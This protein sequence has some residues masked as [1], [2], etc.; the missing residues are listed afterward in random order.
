M[1]GNNMTVFRQELVKME[2]EFNRVLP[3]HLPPQRLTRTIESAVMADPKLLDCDRRS[4][5]RAC[6]SAAVFGLEVDGHQSA[7]LRFK[8]KAQLIPMKAGLIALA[9]NAGW[10]VEA[11]SVRKADTFHFSYGD[12]AV[13]HHEPALDAGRGSENPLTHAYAM[14]WPKGSRGDRVFKVLSADIINERRNNSFGYKANSAASP[15]TT[16]PEAMWEKTAIRDVCGDLPWQVHKAEE[17]EGRF[18]RGENTSADKMPDGK[19]N[20]DGEAFEEQ[21]AA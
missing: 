12:G 8:N 3:P 2:D 11:H 20:I 9:F 10:I 5:W 1:P 21:P 16:H 4:F 17:L 19:I 15:W 7:V 14:A 6:M 13:I 18:D